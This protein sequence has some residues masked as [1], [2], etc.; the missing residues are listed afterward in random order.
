MRRRQKHLPPGWSWTTYSAREAGQK[1]WR[2]QSGTWL[3]YWEGSYRSAGQIV[4]VGVGDL[5]ID[6]IAG[7]KRFA[8]LDKNAAV[9]LGRVVLASSQIRILDAILLFI[10]QNSERPSDEG[11]LNIFGNFLLQLH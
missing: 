5:D 9:D 8:G 11:L 3:K 7:F 10:D 1:Q 2:T 4:F 6:H